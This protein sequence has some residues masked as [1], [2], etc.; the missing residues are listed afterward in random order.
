VVS[1]T[2]FKIDISPLRSSRD[3]RVL[4]AAGTVFYLGLMFGFVAVPYQLF[5]LTGSSLAVGIMGAVQLVPLIIFG[6]YGGSL[7]DRL[8]RRT[9]QLVTGTAQAVLAVIL[10]INA[11][12]DSP[13]VWVLYVVGGLTA[14][15]SALQRPSREALIPRVV[16]HDE[17]PAAVALSALGMQIGML[18][19]PALAG[20]VIVGWGLPV[21]YGVEAAA[22]ALATLSLLRLRRHPPSRTTGEGQLASIGAGLR[23]AVQRKDLLGTYLVDLM[24][25][26]MAMPI[27]L[28]P[29][30]AL[31][32]LKRPELLGLLY[33]AEAVGS[34]IITLT[35]GWT[36]HVFRHGR[37]VALAA[38]G[39]GAAIALAGLA[40]NVW[41]ALIFLIAAGA[42][43]MISG[44]FRSVIWNQTV[45]DAMRGRIAG[46]EMISYTVGP[47]GG[48][49]RSG[50]VAD[51]TTVRTAIVSGGILCIAGVAAVAAGARELWRY[52]SRTNEHAVT[53]RTAR[54]A[55]TDGNHAR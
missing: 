46:I 14:T 18:I 11:V 6:L 44:M 4:F 54:A 36:R 3:F 40:P 32:V 38:M 5:Q 30:F 29:A 2:R 25:M 17:I 37:A 9:V 1:L 45:P 50:I 24:G 31:D 42:F 12:L 21:A 27:V 43:D 7:S 26:V 49:L 15:A 8:D 16:A 53:E 52:D 22:L 51:L 34:M 28:F 20:L 19:G 55:R 39:W 33:A 13:Q 23:Y 41:I 47:V 48:Q 10:L 35:S